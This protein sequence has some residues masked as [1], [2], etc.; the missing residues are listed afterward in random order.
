M[1]KESGEDY[2]Y[3]DPV[4]GERIYKRVEQMAADMEREYQERRR[5]PRQVSPPPDAAAMPA[6]LP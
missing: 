5:A 3:L 6:R 2:L 4:E 1:W